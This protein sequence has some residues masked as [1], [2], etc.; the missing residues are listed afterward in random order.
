[1]DIAGMW[2]S[3]RAD[4][5]EIPRAGAYQQ[6][7]APGITVSLTQQCQVSMP[8]TDYSSDEVSVTV[9][10][11]RPGVP[12]QVIIAANFNSPDGSY[13]GPTW[14]VG[15]GQFTATTSQVQA[16]FI[17]MPAG[18]P[19]LGVGAQATWAD[20]APDSAALTYVQIE[21]EPWVLWQWAI[22]TLAVLS[23]SFQSIRSAARSRRKS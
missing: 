8:L 10:S 1:M 4:P 20:G 5:A 12:A 7:A 22:R 14:T 15:N 11:D 13:Q 9:S 3:M 6:T 2:R 21:C 23:S 19:V 17:V 18:W 16:G